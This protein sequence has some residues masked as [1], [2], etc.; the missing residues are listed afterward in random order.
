MTFDFDEVIDRRG[1]N[2]VAR[3][4]FRNYLFGDRGAELVLP[5]ADDETIAMWV[6]DMAFAAPPVAVEAMRARLDHPVFGYTSVLDGELFAAVAA[7]CDRQYQW[8]PEPDHLVTARGVVSAIRDLID[9]HTEPADKVLTLAPA[10]NQFEKSCQRYGRELVVS[11]LREE[12]AGYS[13]DLEDLEA[14]LSDP[15]VRL[16]LLCHPHNPTGRV[17][18]DDELR[19][20]A[21]LCFAHDVLVVSD[22]IHCDLLR[23]GVRHTPLA[24]LFPDS[25]QII[26]CLSASKTFNLAGLGLAQVLLPTEQQRTRWEEQVSTLVNPLSMAATTSVFRHGEPWLED[27]RTYL[28]DNFALV[29]QTLAAELPEAR[30]HT[31]DATY[32]AWVHLGAYVPPDVDLSWVIA[33]STGLLVEGPSL[34]VANAS[35]RIRLNLACPRS[36]LEEALERM[37]R[38]VRPASRS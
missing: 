23:H 33:E 17:W 12:E 13:I 16:F 9:Q 28:D 2:A 37:V 15:S 30:F 24:K 34:F 18:A 8:A 21:E 4:R 22:E 1:T 25:G 27:L 20:M 35:G 14:R 19:A 26:T 29:E 36:V 11:D 38:A 10:Y 3:D 5:C 31:P 6:A 32:L 7:W